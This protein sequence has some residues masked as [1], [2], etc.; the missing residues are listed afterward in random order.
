MAVGDR[1]KT[2]PTQRAVGVVPVRVNI[3]D[4]N[5]PDITVPALTADM[6]PIA[7]VIGELSQAI[8]QIATTQTAILTALQQ[9]AQQAPPEIKVNA[10]EVKMP[11]R[12]RDFDVAFVEDADGIVGMKIRANLPN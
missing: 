3:P 4:I 11:A 5:V 7:K 2:K 8:Q 10:P 12:P 1:L 9:L 6:A